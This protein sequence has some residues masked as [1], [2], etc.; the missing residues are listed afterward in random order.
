MRERAQ[1]VFPLSHSFRTAE[2]SRSNAGVTFVVTIRSSFTASPSV[3]GA[4]ARGG[5]VIDLFRSSIILFYF[6]RRSRSRL[7]FDLSLS[8]CRRRFI[9]IYDPTPADDEIHR[10]FHC[11]FPPPRPSLAPFSCPPLDSS[12]CLRFYF[13]SSKSLP[14]L[15][16]DGRYMSSSRTSD[17]KLS[18]KAI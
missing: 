4:K 18:G 15:P 14:A 2:C 6:P 11:P 17:K 12:S 13:P 1:H 5:G 8:T 16:V 10:L 9:F 7:P 3:P